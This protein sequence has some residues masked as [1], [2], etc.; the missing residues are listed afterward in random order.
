MALSDAALTT[1]NRL[2]AELGLSDDGTI[3]EPL[4]EE[5]SAYLQTEC[6]RS[7]YRA[8]S[9]AEKVAGFGGSRLAVSDHLPIVSVASI[10]FSDGDTS[11]TIDATDYELEDVA[12]GFIRH[13]GGGWKWT[14]RSNYGITH[15][16]AA[17]TEEP[18]YTVTYTGGYITPQ[19]ADDGVGT[20]DLP[21]DVERAAIDLA[22]A[23]YWARNRDPGVRGKAVSRASVQYAGALHE[24]PSVSPVVARYRRLGSA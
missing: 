11:T 9:Y 7:F 6:G 17:G 12:A 1:V 23:L 22:K 4:I 20:R 5:A 13:N 19:Q 18:L 2:N 3:L 8:S 14:A 15:D 16:P 24:I 10:V 21:Y